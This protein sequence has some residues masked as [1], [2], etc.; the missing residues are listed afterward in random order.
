[1][2]AEYRAAN[3]SNIS[4]LE[5]R[6]DRAIG[7]AKN[8]VIKRGHAIRARLQLPRMARTVDVMVSAVQ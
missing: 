6:A 4:Y 8:Y 7:E 1:M 2:N 5:S 3:A